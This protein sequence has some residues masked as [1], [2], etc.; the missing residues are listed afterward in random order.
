[1]QFKQT[2]KV[3]RRKKREAY[4]ASITI[5]VEKEQKKQIAEHSSRKS[6]R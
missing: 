5:K 1:M 4:N 2:R 6:Q 3:I